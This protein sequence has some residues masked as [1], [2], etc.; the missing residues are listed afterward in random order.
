[1]AGGIVTDYVN[2][3]STVA[4][5]TFAGGLN[6]GSGNL[7]YDLSTG[8]TS[9]NNLAIGS[10]NFDT[11]AGI[12]NWAD[13]PISSSPSGGTVES[14]TA[15]VGGQG[16]LTVY[17]EADGSGGVQNLRVGIGTT[18]PVSTLSITGTSIISG[19]AA[20]PLVLERTTASANIGMEFRNP[21]ASW[22]AGQDANGNFSMNTSANLASSPRFSLT[23]GGALTIAGALTQNS[24]ERLK[25]NIQ[26]FSGT[27]SALTL[28][29]ELNPVT[30]NWLDPRQGS[31]TQYGFIAQE[32]QKIFPDLVINT[33]YVSSTTPDGALALN[34]IGLITPIVK[35][36]QSIAAISDEFKTNL[37]NW[38]A[39]AQNGITKLFAKEVHTDMLCVGS[40][41][42][43]QSQFLAMV[44]AANQAPASA[45]PPPAQPSP[46]ASSTP[47]TS[48][49]TSTPEVTPPQDD[50]ASSTPEVLPAD[51]T[52][53]PAPV[54]DETIAASLASSTPEQ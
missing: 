39:D 49:A 42:V 13:L 36:I 44:N 34:Y 22:Y 10:F 24:D 4:T 20:E 47:P 41:C 2:A 51:N 50:A 12:V 15:N 18:S 54:S 35:G 21:T 3:T 16:V 28:L 52:P 37:V 7:V 5:S 43:T 14:Y 25:T 38:L 30:Y 6:V 45:A 48:E 31:S 19:S 27:S 11:D 32:V 8:V 9:I 40:T 1:M 26:A 33:G 17:G 23:T 29:E 46:A 53:P